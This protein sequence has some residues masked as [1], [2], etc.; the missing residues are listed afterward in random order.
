[1]LT[2]EYLKSILNY[3]FETGIFTRKIPKKQINVNSIIGTKDK[4][5][6]VIIQIVGKKYK[7]HRLAWLYVHGEMPKHNIDHIN[8][9]KDD[10]RIE[11]LR[12]VS[13]TINQQNHRKARKD[14]KSGYLGVSW[15][16]IANKWI[17]HITINKKAKHLGLFETA[18][19]AHE[20]YLKAKRTMHEGCT[21]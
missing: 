10:N 15:S 13:N 6:Y 16:K 14:N 9:I 20:A 3:N 11:N 17:C 21:I 7:A 5:G 12:D 1:M 18:E 4:D 8:G 19:L 2:Q